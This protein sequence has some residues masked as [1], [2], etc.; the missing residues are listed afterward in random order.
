MI[1]LVVYTLIGIITYFNG[2]ARG[3]KGLVT[4]GGILLGLVVAR[5]LFVDVWN[6]ELTGRIITFFLIGAL[7][8]GTAFLGKR[9]ELRII[10]EKTR[11]HA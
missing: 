8:I 3:S 10:E 6:M 5:L 7:L 2:R 4:Y 11:D 9:S 1:A